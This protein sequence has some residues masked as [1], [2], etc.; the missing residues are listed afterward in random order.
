MLVRRLPILLI[1]R[2]IARARQSGKAEV[3]ERHIERF[4]EGTLNGRLVKR[5]VVANLVVDQEV[6]TRTFPEGPGE[7]D[8]VAI[9]EIDKGKIARDWF[10]MGTPR[11]RP[12][13][14]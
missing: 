3:R 13:A 4:A 14:A 1:P 12:E 2:P 7:V 6:V 8:V 10:K 9:Y 11:V 5:I